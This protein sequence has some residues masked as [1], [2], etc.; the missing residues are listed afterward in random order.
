MA[1]T[2]N[3]RK[4][5]MLLI[6]V[7]VVFIV[8]AAIAGYFIWRGTGFYTLPPETADDTLERYAFTDDTIWYTI[9]NEAFGI[10]NT[11]E[12]ARATTDGI[13]SALAW[14]KTQG[15]KNIRF[16]D[17]IYQIQCTWDNRFV[18]PTDGILV[19]SGLTLDLGSATFRLEISDQPAYCIFGIVGQ[20]DVTILGGT[21]IGD[22][23][24][25]IYSSSTQSFTH[26]WGFGICI[27]ASSH[28]L[29]QGV[30]VTDMTG[31]GIIIEGSYDYLS[32]GG[33]MSDGVKIYDCEISHCR[34]QG[35]S[36]VGAINSEIAGNTIYDIKGTDPQYGID[37]ESELDYTT[38]NI[39]V[40][41]NLIYG[42]ARGAISCNNGSDYSVYANVCKG[43]DIIAVK[44]SQV[45][46]YH[47]T[48]QSSM[49]H[50]Y[51]QATNVDTY[52]NQLDFFSRL[53]I[54]N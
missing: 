24:R 26:E 1:R 15:Y 41:H 53:L 33:S 19:P 22:L 5:K 13:N 8:A 27:S 39:M 4:L 10:D 3:K 50:V 18:A 51:S 14:A 54:E 20:D 35:I 47:N 36:V 30:T 49:I 21:L 2:I 46:I 38:K 16:A 31:D 34:R 11:G 25:H 32:N 6:P 52:D 9:D 43:N 29:I 42:C 44:C 45:N 40:H 28:V 12:N 48:I 23:G 37:I 17:G 7:A